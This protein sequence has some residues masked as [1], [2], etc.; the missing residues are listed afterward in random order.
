MAIEYVRSY[1]Y[2]DDARYASNFI[3]LKKQQKSKRAL[4]FELQNKG[5]PRDIIQQCMEEEFA[6]EDETEAIKKLIRKKCNNVTDVDDVKVQK[7]IASIC[8]KGFSFEKIRSAIREL[9]EEENL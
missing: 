8:R 1:G 5:I 9:E 2:I 7:I 4:E 3:R 6:Y